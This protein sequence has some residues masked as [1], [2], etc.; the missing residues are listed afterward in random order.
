MYKQLYTF[1]LNAGECSTLNISKLMVLDFWVK[2]ALF[3]SYDLLTSNAVSDFPDDQPAHSGFP[4][5]FKL[6]HVDLLLYNSYSL[7]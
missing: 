4:C 5:I 3:Y 6:I 1:K 7:L 2:A